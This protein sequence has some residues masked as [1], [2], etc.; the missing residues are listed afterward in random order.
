MRDFTSMPIRA[1]PFDHQCRAYSD[2]L[3]VFYSAKSPGYA[4]LMEMGCGKSLTAIGIA[5]RLY[6]DGNVNRV[7]V[8]APLSIVGLWDDGVRQIRG[9]RLQPH[10]A[11]RNRRKESAA[12]ERAWLV[13]NP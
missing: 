10:C 2:A 9:F 13:Q 3:D 11:E 6:L 1:Q 8:V 5:G 12:V 4:L 7:L